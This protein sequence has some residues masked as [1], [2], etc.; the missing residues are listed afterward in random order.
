[1][2]NRKF[3]LLVIF[4]FVL[5]ISLT[6]FRKDTS[7]GFLTG[8]SDTL[9]RIQVSVPSNHTIQFTTPSGVNSASQTIVVGFNTEAPAFGMTSIG[10]GDIDLFT[11]TTN[12]CTGTPTS[13]T[14]AA[15][16]NTDVWGVA[17]NSGAG[18]ITFTAPTN[19]TTGEIA[20]GGCVQILIGTH[21]VS[22]TNQITNPSVQSTYSVGISGSF[23]DT[24]YASVRIITDDQ[25]DISASVDPTL[26]VVI[27]SNTCALGVLTATFIKTCQYDVTVSTNA[28]NGYVSTI[29]ADGN[30]RNSLNSI[31]NVAGG[32]VE[33]GSEE[34]GVG[35]SKASQDIAQNSL[36]TNNDTGASQ[37]AS[38]LTTSAQRFAS[39]TTP[40][41]SDTTT[42]CHLASVSGATPAGSYAQV[43]TVI[44]TANY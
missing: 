21:A 33:K 26:D 19:A 6:Y 32:S 24:G 37:P 28:Q 4:V 18:T 27:S 39:S 41:S 15:S 34:Y 23:G 1:M 40:V 10:F 42:M 36:C 2:K 43:A 12:N 20:A 13:K 30:L 5:S 8:I 7:A 25:I 17:V 16:A 3:L 44:V 11:Y 14:L 31:T 35:T 9:S 29:L 38:A 22:G